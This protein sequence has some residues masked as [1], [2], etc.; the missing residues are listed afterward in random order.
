MDFFDF[1]F[2]PAGNIIHSAGVLTRPIVW[3]IAVSDNCLGLGFGVTAGKDETNIAIFVQKSKISSPEEHTT[4]VDVDDRS[5][6]MVC[7]IRCKIDYGSGDLL[8]PGHA[9]ARNLF[10]YGSDLSSIAEDV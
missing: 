2:S 7:E 5:N 1:V 10:V 4:T 9:A 6:N 8:G 3:S